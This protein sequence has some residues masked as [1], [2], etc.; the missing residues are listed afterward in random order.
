MVSEKFR[1]AESQCK[2]LNGQ[3]DGPWHDCMAFS[4]T[5][6]EVIEILKIAGLV[7]FGVFLIVCLVYRYRNKIRLD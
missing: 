2:D 5:I 4:Q 6:Y 1:Y 3:W 7:L